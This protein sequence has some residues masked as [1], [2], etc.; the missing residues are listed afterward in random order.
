LLAEGPIG[1]TGNMGERLAWLS[2]AS[3]GLKAGQTIF[4]G[5]PATAH[6]ATPGII[7]LHGPRNSVLVAEL[8]D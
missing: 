6:E 1:D 4:M 7:E 2:K 3:G 5:S 8:H